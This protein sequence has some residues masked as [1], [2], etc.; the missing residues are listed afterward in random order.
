[1]V[2]H[3]R[4]LARG[5]CAEAIAV[6]SKIMTN[7]KSPPA[8][9]VAAA[10]A[11]LDRGYDR[12]EAVPDARS[13]HEPANFRWR[14][15]FEKRRGIATNINGLLHAKAEENQYLPYRASLR[16]LS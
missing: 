5:H 4:E 10:K 9:R 12:S 1:M 13:R 3:V 11:A 14:V 6:L 16:L 15:Y 8:A 2:R 7:A